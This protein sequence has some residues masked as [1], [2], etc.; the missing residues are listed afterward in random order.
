MKTQQEVLTE[1]YLALKAT[2]EV[3]SLKD[4]AA[5][6]GI[7]YTSLTKAK[8]SGKVNFSKGM[9]AKILKAFQ[10]VNPRFLQKGEG[11]VFLPKEQVHIV[12]AEGSISIAGN[13]NNN[14][15]DSAIALEALRALT[16]EQELHKQAN[17]QIT[18]LL[19]IIK[20]KS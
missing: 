17:A 15:T 16:N 20:N 7:E 3:Y 8:K 14:K 19:D 11:N 10:Q 9:Q 6:T 12:T 13:N 18:T 5:K 2:R 1:L 4:F